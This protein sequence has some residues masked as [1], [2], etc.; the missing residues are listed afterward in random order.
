MDGDQVVIQVQLID[1]HSRE[2]LGQGSIEVG[3]RKDLLTAMD[4]DKAQDWF[5]TT[6]AAMGTIAYR[7]AYPRSGRGERHG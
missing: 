3:L 1:P 2:V 5:S 7:E 4:A 6:C